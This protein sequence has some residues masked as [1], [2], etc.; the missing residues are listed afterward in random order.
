MSLMKDAAKVAED[1]LKKDRAEMAKNNQ[2]QMEE[3]AKIRPTP[4][5]EEVQKAMGVTPKKKAEFKPEEKV[6]PKAAEP[7]AME[8]KPDKSGYVTRDTQAASKK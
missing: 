1:A 4:T 2:K 7:K 6:G 8:A 3:L 5:I